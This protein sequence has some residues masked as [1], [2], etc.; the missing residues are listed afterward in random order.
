MSLG[1]RG[2]AAVGAALLEITSSNSLNS[3]AQIKSTDHSYYS[4]SKS[5]NL[6][7]R[8]PKYVP[9]MKKSFHNKNVLQINTEK[10]RCQYCMQNKKS[11]HPH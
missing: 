6:D 4:R 8:A 5:H 7:E 11:D 10:E 3:G 1:T 9:N 2:A